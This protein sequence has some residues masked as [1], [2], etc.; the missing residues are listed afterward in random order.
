MK[1]QN[2]LKIL[3]FLLGL[4]LL[5]A[6]EPTTADARPHRHHRSKPASTTVKA[7]PL[8]TVKLS[9]DAKSSALA[10]NHAVLQGA[11]RGVRVPPPATTLPRNTRQIAE[12][13]WIGGIP[14]VRNIDALYNK[15][16]RLIISAT[17]VSAEFEPVK[18]HIAELGIKHIILPFGGKFPKS[19]AFY[20]TVLKFLPEHTYIH[21]DHG[22]DRSGSLL[23]YLLVKRHSWSIQHALLA[24]L[25][26]GEN[27]IKGMKKVLVDRGYSVS[28]SE[29]TQYAGIYSGARNGSGGG[30]KVRSDD[31][32]KLVNT[33]I[34][35][36]EK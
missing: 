21:C 34:D 10:L 1:R 12:G 16:I 36:L 4:L 11:A 7:D 17:R 9:K 23:A 13:Y 29:V 2:I 20:Q 22:G 8:S 31:Y 24:V 6:T 30:L 28:D 25:F 14:T 5:S 27:D 35:A 15:H 3:C 32:K 33:L 19:T 26:P 18:Q